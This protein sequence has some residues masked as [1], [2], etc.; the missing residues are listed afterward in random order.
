MLLT[1][2]TM[3]FHLL[4]VAVLVLLVWF[5]LYFSRFKYPPFIR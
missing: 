2:I 1:S 4:Y 3:T 5:V